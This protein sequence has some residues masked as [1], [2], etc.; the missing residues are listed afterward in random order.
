MHP[1]ALTA[2]RLW[3]SDRMLV[4]LLVVIVLLVFV[5]PLVPLERPERIALD[6]AFSLLLLSGILTLS[7]S[8]FGVWLGGAIAA[9]A[10]AVRF[11]DRLVPGVELSEWDAVLA[12]AAEA[13]LVSVLLVELFR[14]GAVTPYRLAGAVVVYLL[15]GLMWVNFY[16]VVESLRPGAFHFQTMPAANEIAGRLVYFSF[17]TL[18]TVGYGD[19]IALHPVARSAAN[20]QALTGQLFPAILIARLVAMGFASRK[21]ADGGEGA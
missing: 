18:S 6:L 2:R 3:L 19:V 1:L 14:P 12:L 4:A 16:F 5:L 10:L 8:V 20:L 17:A 7:R 11:L 9:G 15:L 13:C 21:G